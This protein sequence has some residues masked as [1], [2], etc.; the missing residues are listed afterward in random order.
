M[1][2]ELVVQE[3]TLNDLYFCWELD[4]RCFPDG[5]AYEVETFR[6]LLSNP[7]AV[8]RKV[9]LFNGA[10]IGFVVGM[11]EPGAV[12]HVISLGVAPEWRR[13]GIG[14]ELMKSIERGFSE[15]GATTCRL[16]VRVDNRPAQR[17]YR[18][19]GYSVTQRLYSYYSNGDDALVMV[20]PLSGRRS[21]WWFRL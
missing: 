13:R 18:K 3:I 2:T 7:D 12:G 9:G 14:Q 21:F 4:Q 5:E 19:M 20:K 11:L 10:M 8:T 15:R 6:H 1:V 17:L 16:E